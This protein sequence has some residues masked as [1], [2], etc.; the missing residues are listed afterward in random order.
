[1]TDTKK[2]SSNVVRNELLIR[3]QKLNVLLKDSPR[4][5]KKIQFAQLPKMQFIHSLIKNSYINS[6]LKVLYPAGVK[7]VLS[8]VSKDGSETSKI[9]FLLCSDDGICSACWGITATD[10]IKRK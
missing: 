6:W 1:M 4:K 5:K 9:L 3:Q 7:Q 10:R 2:I 8:H